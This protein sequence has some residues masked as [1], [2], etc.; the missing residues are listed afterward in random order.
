M[1][2]GTQIRLQRE[3][4]GLSQDELAKRLF[5]S[6]QTV[7]NWETDKTLPDLESLKLMGLTFDMTVAELLGETGE[8]MVAETA[9]DRRELVLLVIF[10][11]CMMLVW[12][13]WRS[14]RLYY[15][16]V[17]GIDV[18]TS[19]P[20]AALSSVPMLTLCALAIAA[21]LRMGH[22]KDRYNLHSD[23]ELSAYLAEQPYRD[24]PV[25]RLAYRITLRYGFSIVWALY[26]AVMF[27]ELFARW[28]MTSW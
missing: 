8:R 5:V 11:M 20:D 28:G 16:A 12:A 1:K 27:I 19:Q 22:L 14:V 23:R 26:V 25:K 2:I 17:C 13:V 18:P 6:R 24:A 10:N 9:A 3:A 4:A 7:S 15:L 21:L